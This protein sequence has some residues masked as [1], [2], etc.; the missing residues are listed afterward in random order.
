MLAVSNAHAF[1]VQQVD[2]FLAGD[3]SLEAAIPLWQKSARPGELE[4]I[5]NI[6]DP[7][8]VRSHLRF[9]ISETE[10]TLP[11]VSLIFRRNP[12]MRLDIEGPSICHS[13]PP[14]AATLKLPPEVCGSH[15]HSW[16]DNRNHILNTGLWELPARR[17]VEPRLRRV[18]QMLPW[19]AAQVGID[20]THD[21]RSFDLPPR[22]QLL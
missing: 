12:I 6:L 20:L 11:S 16:E 8:G 22:E 1:D 4:A 21:Q 15:F 7:L 9:R 10:P 17:A 13:N 14:W 3:K 2:D 18:P 5:W 19:I